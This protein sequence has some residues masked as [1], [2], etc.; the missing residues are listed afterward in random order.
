MCIEGKDVILEFDDDNTVINLKEF[1]PKI[2]N[3]INLLTTDKFV[4]TIM[5]EARELFYDN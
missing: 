4:K 2:K 1:M 5:K 3:L